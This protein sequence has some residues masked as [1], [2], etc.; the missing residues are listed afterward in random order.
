MHVLKSLKILDLK[1]QFKVFH[2]N[3]SKFGENVT[4]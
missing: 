2:K 4:K 3:V 1:A